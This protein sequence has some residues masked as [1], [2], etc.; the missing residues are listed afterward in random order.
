MESTA[1]H[2]RRWWALGALVLGVLVLGFDMTIL[3]VALPTMAT[4]LGADTGD[5]QWIVDA[6]TIVFAALLLPA[7]LM[8][9]R[10]GRRK[11]IL[12]GLALFGSASLIG[13]FA[14]SIGLVVAARALMGIGAALIMP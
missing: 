4:E 11:L 3:N 2:P 14:D 8:G 1:A 12:I 9:D 13:T 5:L 6:Y 10:F 7:G